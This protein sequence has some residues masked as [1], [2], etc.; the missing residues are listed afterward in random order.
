MRSLVEC[1]VAHGFLLFV[2]PCSDA[3]SRPSAVEADVLDFFL[4]SRASLR[5]GEAMDEI[6]SY[7]NKKLTL[8]CFFF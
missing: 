4:I 5:G 8:S 2:H 1:N 6:K 7:E 3:T